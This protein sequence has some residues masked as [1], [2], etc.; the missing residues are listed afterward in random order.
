MA[1]RTKPKREKRY[2][3]LRLSSSKVLNFSA[4]ICQRND[5]RL[6]DVIGRA[7]ERHITAVRHFIWSELYAQGYSFPEIGR[8]FGRDHTTVLAGV[9]RHNA[10]LAGEID[11]RAGKP[12]GLPR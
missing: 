1:P 8:E 4:L 6:S 12:W 9:R 7:R 10:R 5:V 11:K 3:S 2:N